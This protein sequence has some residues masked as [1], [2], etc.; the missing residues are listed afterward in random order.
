MS[1]MAP[2]YFGSALV[3]ALKDTVMMW[4]AAYWTHVLFVS[5]VS[6]LPSARACWGLWG[7]GDPE[8]G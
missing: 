3:V 2:G 4:Y 7:L 6:A 8:S 1:Q 5:D